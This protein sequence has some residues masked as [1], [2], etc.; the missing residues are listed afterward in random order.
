MSFKQDLIKLGMTNPELRPHIRHILAGCEKLPEGGM[1]DN[2][3]KKQ[4]E[5]GKKDDEKK[6]AGFKSAAF[7]NR[8]PMSYHIWAEKTL[9]FLDRSGDPGTTR[10]LSFAF[11]VYLLSLTAPDQ[12]VMIDRILTRFRNKPVDPTEPQGEGASPIF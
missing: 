4:E 2:C 11:C 3:E 6:E 8:L 1:R 7:I 12:A 10:D 5:G 9:A